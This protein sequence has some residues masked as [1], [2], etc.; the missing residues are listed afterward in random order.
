MRG[1]TFRLRKLG[2]VPRSF[3]AKFIVVVGAAVLFDL[4]LSGGI[5]FWNVNR[6][7][8]DATGKIERGLTEANQEYVKNYIETTA[9]RA[10]LVL[11]RVHSEVTALA[12]SMQ[13][14]IDHPEA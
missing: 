14:L 11:D 6:L 3:R 9:V 4:L 5:A 8:H 7:S 12:L 2:L 13:A 10:D 1:V